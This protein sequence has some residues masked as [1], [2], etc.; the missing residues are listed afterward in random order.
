MFPTLGIAADNS[1]EPAGDA[2]G[3]FDGVD[4]KE[5]E[6]VS[7]LDKGRYLRRDGLSD[8]RFA[9]QELQEFFSKILIAYS[10]KTIEATQ[11]SNLAN[12][13]TS[14]PDGVLRG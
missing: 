5:H 14:S 12:K 6:G 10:V 9:P 13:K 8:H 1:L 11:K 7:V 4:G 2:A 3:L